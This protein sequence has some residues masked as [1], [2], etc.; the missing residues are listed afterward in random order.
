MPSQNE[1]DFSSAGQAP[2]LSLARKI[3][4]RLWPYRWIF[5]VAVVQVL[6]IGALELLKP[7][8]L[9]LVVEHVLTGHTVLWAAGFCTADAAPAW[10][11]DTCAGVRADRCV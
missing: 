5:A 1:K 9:K 3:C 2:L 10:L 11:P 8:P 7:W 6:L 4:K